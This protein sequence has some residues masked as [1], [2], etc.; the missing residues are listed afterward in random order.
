M[1][2]IMAVFVVN[3]FSGLPTLESYVRLC[4]HI[5]ARSPYLFHQWNVDL[6][7][8]PELFRRRDVLAIFG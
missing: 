4:M 1:N 8:L 3:L 2:D 5:T 6:F 7:L